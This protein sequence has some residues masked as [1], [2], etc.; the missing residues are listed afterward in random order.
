MLLRLHRN[1]ELVFL[2]GFLFYHLPLPLH[3]LLDNLSPEL[4]M[5]PSVHWRLLHEDQLVD[6]RRY[7]RIPKGLTRLAEEARL[8]G[9]LIRFRQRAVTNKSFSLLP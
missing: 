4:L 6:S 1:L 7:S 2:D 9:K 3:E 8:A 5:A